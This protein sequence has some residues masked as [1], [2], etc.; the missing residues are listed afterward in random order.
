M[1]WI[2]IKA[3][4]QTKTFAMN[5]IMELKLQTFQIQGSAHQYLIKAVLDYRILKYNLITPKMVLETLR[6]LK[7]GCIMKTNFKVNNL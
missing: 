3:R 4:E 2:S 7:K 1:L 5:K 6:I